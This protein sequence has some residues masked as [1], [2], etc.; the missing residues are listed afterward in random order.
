MLW[1]IALFLMVLWLFGW[2]NGAMMG[3]WCIHALL[4]SI[5]QG[6]RPLNQPEVIHKPV[7]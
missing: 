6:R 7:L 3:G 2:V 5:I 4:S 1:T